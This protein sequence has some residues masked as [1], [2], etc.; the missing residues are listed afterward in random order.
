MST[1]ETIKQLRE[2]T[3]AG[4]VDCQKALAATNGDMTAAIDQLRKQGLE[5]AGKKA[6]RSTAEGVI[7]VAKNAAAVAVVGLACETDFVARNADFV[8]AAQ[9]LSDQLLASGDVAAFSPVANQ[10]ITGELMVKIGE[11][12]KLACADYVTGANVGS[13]LHSNQKIAAVVA[14]SGGSAD[15][16]ADLAMHVAASAPQYLAGADVPAE[17]VAKEREI[18]AEQMA[19][20]NKPAEV[21]V[22]IIDGKL[23]KFYAEVCLVKQPFVKDDSQTI[24]QLLGDVKVEKF[25]RYQ[26]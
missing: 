8:V 7:A 20:E 25:A 3:G 15:L 23:N 21:L 2:R 22:K 13:Y 16:A 14:L 6:E 12:M 10:K 19:G 4:M 24:E 17:V 5:K 11:N 26:I 9:T 1:L 18:Y